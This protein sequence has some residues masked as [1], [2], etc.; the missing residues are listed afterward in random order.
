MIAKTLTRCEF[1]HIKSAL[2]EFR[3]WVTEY[4]ETVTSRQEDQLAIAEEIMKHEDS[5]S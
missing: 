3:Y 2:D 1:L 5:V 4:P